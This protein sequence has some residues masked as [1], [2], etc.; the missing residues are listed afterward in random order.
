MNVAVHTQGNQIRKQ[1]V[2]AL[3]KQK[4][5]VAIALMLIAMLFSDS[6]FYTQ[7][8]IMNIFRAAS[9]NL[10]IAFG[11]TL[12]VICRG[13]DLSVG[14]VMS[15]SGIIAILL[16]NNGMNMYMAM[17]VAALSGAVVGFIN[18]FLVVHQK[19]EAF[20][21]TL[22]MGMLVKGIAL[23]LTDANP[24]PTSRDKALAFMRISNGV[25]L[26]IPHIMWYMLILGAFTFWLL[27]FT[28]FG[29]NCYALGGDYEVAKYSGINVVRTKWIAFT[30]T[31]TY[32]AVAGVLLASRMNTGSAIYGDAIPLMVN[33]G[34]VIGGTS[35][36]GG[37]G[38]V[39]HSFI[40]IM[41]MQLLR[42]CMNG[43][44]I[45]PYIQQM[46]LGVVIVGIICMDCYAIKRK[47]ED[48]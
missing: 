47:K 4:A 28:S 46:V 37:T 44:G 12:A 14:S 32:A 43:F 16:I 5:V 17:I 34:V 21:I 22:G 13:C 25:F 2:Q 9:P 45:D 19:T 48:V 36:A 24:V 42:N 23:Q 41:V 39:V 1:V 11:V 40:G 31:G 30:L 3:S 7:L 33:C 15:M 38:G 20:I 35:F 26:G 6:N 10:I 29:R 27:R 18:G 8:N